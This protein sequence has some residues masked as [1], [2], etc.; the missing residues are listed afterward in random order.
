MSDN[1]IKCKRCLIRDLNDTDRMKIIDDYK[2]M[3]PQNK[4]ADSQTYEKR[5]AVCLDCKWL[6]MGTC[7]K[8][9]FLVEARAFVNSNHCPL[10]D[11]VW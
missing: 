9:G 11:K 5:L 6:N 2:S 8:C 4:A 1:K 7:L 3:I 10:G